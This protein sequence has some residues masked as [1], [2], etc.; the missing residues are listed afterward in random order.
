MNSCLDRRRSRLDRIEQLGAGQEHDAGAG[1]GQHQSAIAGVD[2][3]IVATAFDGA[4]GERVDHQ[5]HLG[6]GLDREES[7]ESSHVHGD[8]LIKPHAN[9]AVPPVPD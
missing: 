9:R 3:Q 8:K 5:P 4:E 6:A 7:G 2:F 1:E